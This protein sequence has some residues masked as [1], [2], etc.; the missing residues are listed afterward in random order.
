[1][2]RVFLHFG[3]GALAVFFPFVVMLVQSFPWLWL[4]RYVQGFPDSVLCACFPIT[5]VMHVQF[6]YI[7]YMYDVLCSVF[8]H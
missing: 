1:M 4:C 2:H 6:G 3:Y 8:S 5:V 7:P